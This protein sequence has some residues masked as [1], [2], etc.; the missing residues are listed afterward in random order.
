[1]RRW[2]NLILFLSLIPS[3]LSLAPRLEA[4][5]PGPVVLMLDGNAAL[6]EAA[7]R[8][9]SL[10]DLLA[11]YRK[12]GV[13]GV[14]VYESTVAD[15]VR[16]GRV[17]YQ[18][19]ATLRLL[20]PEAGFDPGWYYA[21]GDEAVLSRLRTAWRLPQHRVYWEGRVWLGFP[22]NVEKFP[23][24]PPDELLELYRQGYYIGYR[25]I[26]H[27]DRAYPVAFPEGVSIVIFAGT[28]ALGYPDHLQE[29][30]R[31]LPVPVAFIEGARQAGFDAIAARVPVL[32]LFSLQAEWQ[33]K[34]APEVAADKYLLAARERGH[35]ILYFRPY[36]TPER[37][38]RFLRR[39]TEG[40]EAS[41]IP[42]GEPRVREFTPSPLRYAAWAGVAAGLG[43]LALGYPQPLGALLALGLVGGAWAYAGAYAGPLLAALVFPVLGFVSGARGFAMWGAATGYALA[44]AVLLSA[45]GSQPETVLGLIPFKGVSLTLLVPP[46]LVAFSFL[47]K[48]PVPQS[49][50]ALWNH[51]VRLGEVAL[52]LAAL[53]A[54]A[55]VFLRRGN[56]API[57]LDL[58]LQLRAWLSDWMVRPRFKELLGHG[59]A[60]VAWGAA[61]PAWVRNGMLLFVAIGEASI[62]NTFSHY[63]TP[64]GVSLARTLNGMVAGLML[65]A[66]ALIIIR[67]IRRWWSA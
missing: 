29:V 19:G 32:R 58:E 47:P 50:A 44:G 37:T 45:L 21:T 42:L 67:G 65:G 1:M 48:R 61:W 60:V 53:A 52:A 43:L 31:G 25:P 24:G 33:L 46:V 16:A 14:G 36:P 64:L 40:L 54:L 26:N 9:V 30:A 27:P 11:E 59:M 55:L 41:G 12:L 5:R 23:V 51:P 22:V 6:E 57:V 8:G 4:E 28:E 34:L 38:E 63:H 7:R 13:R 49:L 2:L 35:Q 62:L 3:L 17:L 56:D 18:P 20:F 15:L 39:I 10:P 66:A